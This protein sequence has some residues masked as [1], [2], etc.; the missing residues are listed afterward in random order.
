MQLR[1][2]N[3]VYPFD[4]ADPFVLR[5]NQGYF[6]YSTAAVGGEERIFPILHSEKLSKWR[7]IG[8]ALTPPKDQRIYAYWASEVA[9]QDGGR[10]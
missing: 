1:Y 7:R 8:G 5:T 10:Y 4:F 9:E 3:P 2:K 6:A